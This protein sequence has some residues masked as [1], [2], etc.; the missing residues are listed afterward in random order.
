M[1][2]SREHFSMTMAL[3]EDNPRALALRGRHRMAT[4]EMHAN[5]NFRFRTMSDGSTLG[6]KRYFAFSHGAVPSWWGAEGIS[7]KEPV[8]GVYENQAGTSTDAIMLTEDRIVILQAEGPVEIRLREIV[9][10][11]PPQKEPLSLSLTAHLTS[12]Q[13]IEIPLY[14]PPGIAFDFY[15]F[16]IYAIRVEQGHAGG[17]HDK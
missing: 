17:A 6:T 16:L 15:R 3:F 7:S 8:I 11:D 9:R 12:G 14:D 13:A 5:R 1:L 10:A 4:V 2:T